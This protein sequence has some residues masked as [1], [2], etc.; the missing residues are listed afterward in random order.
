MIGYVLKIDY[1]IYRP[2][3]LEN[4][5]ASLKVFTKKL[6]TI[7]VLAQNTIDKCIPALRSTEIGVELVNNIPN[8][9]TRTCLVEHLQ[10]KHENITQNFLREI[11]AVKDEFLVWLNVL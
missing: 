5:E 10:Q 6:K 7:E 9:N 11:Q 3:N 2:G 4:W 8:L 1:D